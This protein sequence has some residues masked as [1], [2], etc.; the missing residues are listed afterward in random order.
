[1]SLAWDW[2]DHWKTSRPEPTTVGCAACGQEI[3]RGVKPDWL[4][5]AVFPSLTDETL[6]C[7]GDCLESWLADHVLE[8]V[9]HGEPA[10][11]E[12][13]LAVAEGA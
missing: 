3:G 10:H 7:D 12:C 2:Y 8:A 13:G 5:R 11:V 9:A 1:M 6:F 4:L